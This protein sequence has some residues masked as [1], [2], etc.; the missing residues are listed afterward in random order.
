MKRKIFSL[1]VALVLMLVAIPAGAEEIV[2]WQNLG[3]DAMDGWTVAAGSTGTATIDTEVKAEGTGALKIV[4][5]E[6]QTTT[7]TQSIALPAS[8]RG[9]HFSVRAQLKVVSASGNG[10]RLEVRKSD[11]SYSRYGNDNEARTAY[12]TTTDEKFI[13]LD[14][15]PYKSGSYVLTLILDGAGEVY[16]DDIKI[17]EIFGWGNSDFEGYKGY[18]ETTKTVGGMWTTTGDSASIQND[19]EQGNYIY[20]EDTSDYLKSTYMLRLTPGKMYRVSWKCK[21]IGAYYLQASLY[22]DKA[23]SASNALTKETWSFGQSTGN[24]WSTGE[25][26]FTMPGDRWGIALN[27]RGRQGGFS[28]DDIMLEEVAETAVSFAEGEEGATNITTAVASAASDEKAFILICRYGKDGTARVL[29]DVK[30]VAPTLTSS[31]ALGTIPVVYLGTQTESVTTEAGDT[32]EVMRWNSA[33]GL[34]PMM[35]KIV[36]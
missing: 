24:A 23:Y 25:Y 12:I 32:I 11:G 20:L 17:N 8:F 14:I 28:I 7:V 21:T 29:K 3:L 4:N 30:V 31:F 18:T 34:S 27:F 22:V 6:G 16:F 10:A 35:D 26:Y 1:M 15:A 33:S 9:S 13:L 2:Y 5:A 19:T 36:R